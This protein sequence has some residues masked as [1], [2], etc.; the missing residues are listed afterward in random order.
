VIWVLIAVMIGM[1]PCIPML[2]LAYTATTKNEE[3]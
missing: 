1:L 2:A 3:R